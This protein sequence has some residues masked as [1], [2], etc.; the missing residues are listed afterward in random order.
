MDISVLSICVLFVWVVYAYLY[1]SDWNMI[2]RSVERKQSRS[3][4]GLLSGLMDAI[5]RRAREKLRMVDITAFVCLHTIGQ[6]DEISFSHRNH[7]A[8]LVLRWLDAILMKFEK[9][10]DKFIK[11]G[12]NNK[13]QSSCCFRTRTK[14]SL[15]ATIIVTN[16]DLFFY[17]TFYN[18]VTAARSRSHCPIPGLL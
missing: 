6:F 15:G 11:Q 9:E 7:R 8:I 4:K 3:G 17:V 14:Q 5:S 12:R 13:R 2:K 18:T 1:L 16:I 10:R